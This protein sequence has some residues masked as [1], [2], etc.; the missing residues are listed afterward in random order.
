M[1]RYVDVSEETLKIFEE[2]LNNSSIPANIVEIR[3]MDNTKLKE[4]SKIQK[5]ND[6]VETLTEGLNVVIVI[7]SK[8]FDELPEEEMK[9]MVFD[10]ALAGVEV[11]MESGKV[12]IA[13]PNICTYSGMLTKYGDS[14][15]IRFKETV[16][17]IF[18]KIKADEDAEKAA[19]KEKKAK[20][21]KTNVE[22]VL[23]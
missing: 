10:E 1:A 3:V 20:K 4:I 7:N 23:S 8:A 13:P 21:G 2:V 18:D 16:I 22:V 6:L 17:S 11:N 15:M 9:K 14:N 12:T 5:L 19:K